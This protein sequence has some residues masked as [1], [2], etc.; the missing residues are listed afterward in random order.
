MQLTADHCRSN[1]SFVLLDD[2][3]GVSFHQELSDP[4][5]QGCTQP[6]EQGLVLRHVVSCFEV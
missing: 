4:H 2:E 6:K 5:R 3:L 1:L